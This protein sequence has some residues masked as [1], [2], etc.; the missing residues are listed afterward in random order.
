VHW[1]SRLRLL[2]PFSAKLANAMRIAYGG[3]GIERP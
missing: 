3:H 2:E 1:L